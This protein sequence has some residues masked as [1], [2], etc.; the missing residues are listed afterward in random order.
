MSE[1]EKSVKTYCL[2][3]DRFVFC[4]LYVH[5]GFLG[6]LGLYTVSVELP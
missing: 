5:L 1:L 3:I 6:M 2:W 4:W